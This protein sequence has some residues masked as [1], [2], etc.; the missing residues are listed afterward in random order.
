MDLVDP[1]IDMVA[2]ARAFGV[3]AVAATTI[4]EVMAAVADGLPSG[5]PVVVDAAVD[6]DL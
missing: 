5:R 2:L 1:E 3:D 6:G 4:P